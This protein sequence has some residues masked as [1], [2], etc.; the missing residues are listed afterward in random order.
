VRSSPDAGAA[1]VG[2]AALLAAGAC[3][4]S[5]AGADG[6]DWRPALAWRE[7]WRAWTAAV[8]HLSPLHLAANVAGAAL[9]AAFGR[10]ARVPRAAVL[11]WLVA[12]PLTQ[13]GLVLRPDLA[14]YGGL[15]GVLHAG[16]AIVALHLVVAGPAVRRAIGAATLAALLAKVLAEAPWGP[17]ARPL[18]GWD[19]AVA[20]FAHA[21]GLVAGLLAG[22]AAMLVQRRSGRREA[23]P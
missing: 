2:L 7:P 10:A 13:L 5:F 17:A 12:W 21:S 11:A 15:S 9:V 4:A 8:V 20:P 3:L 23:P 14:T 18:P 16:V 6:L 22:A 19:I 1:W